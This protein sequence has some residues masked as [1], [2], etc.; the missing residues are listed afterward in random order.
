MLKN[1]DKTFSMERLYRL[2]EGWYRN[3]S[4]LPVPRTDSLSSLAE[5]L[6]IPCGTWIYPGGVPDAA[7]ISTCCPDYIKHCHI[8]HAWLCC[9]SHAC[10][11]SPLLVTN[12]TVSFEGTTS[13]IQYNIQ[14]NLTA[15]CQY[16]CTRNVLWASYTHHTFTPIMK[17]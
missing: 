12:S 2:T 3:I 13:T 17:H 16:I 7:H 5:A 15:K 9:D 1:I 8:S 4:L 14:Y 11:L 6:F 10:I